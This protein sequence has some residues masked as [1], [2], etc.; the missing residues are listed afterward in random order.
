[1]HTKLSNKIWYIFYRQNEGA[2]PARPSSAGELPPL[3]RTGSPTGAEKDILV[4]ICFGFLLNGS[5]LI[6]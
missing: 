3:E 6:Y 1:M 5:V 2:V 4:H